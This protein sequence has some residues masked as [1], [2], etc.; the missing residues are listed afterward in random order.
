M[1]EPGILPDVESDNILNYLRLRL[2]DPQAGQNV[3]RSIN[4]QVSVFDVEEQLEVHGDAKLH[5]DP[6]N[7]QRCSFQTMDSGPQEAQ[8]LSTCQPPDNKVTTHNKTIKQ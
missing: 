8:S 6:Q 3:V 2:Q 1:C 5:K 7:P 4:K